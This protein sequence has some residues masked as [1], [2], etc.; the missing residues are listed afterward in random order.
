[1]NKWE[2]LKTLKT[3]L[4]RNGIQQAEDILSDYE[5][6]FTHGLNK[7]KTEVEIS[8]ALGHPSTIAKAYKTESLISEIKNPQNGF[9]WS[10]AFNIIG[11]LLVI[12][13]FNFIIL[14]IPGA[15]ILALLASGWATSVAIAAAGLAGFALLPVLTTLSVNVWAWVAGLSTILGLIGLA[16]VT[17]LVMFIITKHIILAAINYLQWNLKFVLQK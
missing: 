7:G 12:A 6:H 10:L 16:A 3:E 15:L 8:E 1:M 9:Q 4:E 2:F 13:P 5:E 14:F 11:R 17:G